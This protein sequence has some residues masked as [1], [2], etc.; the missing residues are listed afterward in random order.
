MADRVRRRQPMQ[1]CVDR[2]T[3]GPRGRGHALADGTCP[4]T[5]THPVLGKLDALAFSRPCAVCTNPLGKDS[6]P[7]V[8]SA[9]HCGQGLHSRRCPN[10]SGRTEGGYP[11]RLPSGSAR[12]TRL[13]T[14]T[15]TMARDVP[16]LLTR[17]E[18]PLTKT[19]LCS[20]ARCPLPEVRRLAGHVEHIQQR[21]LRRRRLPE[22]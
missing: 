4:R 1:R 19:R 22:L 2:Y 10:T 13:Q 12:E 5:E 14:R 16:C 7:K 11:L 3:G 20:A 6:A 9:K 21:R 8:A 17:G 18:T 15:R